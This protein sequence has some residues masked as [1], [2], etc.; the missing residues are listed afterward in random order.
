MKRQSILVLA[1]LILVVTGTSRAVVTCYIKTLD[2]T[3]YRDGCAVGSFGPS[4]TYGQTFTVP[5]GYPFLQSAQFYVNVWPTD[6]KFA[7]STLDFK[8]YVAAW[9][10]NA[11]T[12]S[13]LF[14]GPLISMGI[15]PDEYQY[16]SV[17]VNFNGL[18]LNI[19]EQYIIIASVEPMGWTGKAN[20]R[21]EATCHDSGSLNDGFY[22]TNNID[23][24]NPPSVNWMGAKA[25]PEDF[26]LLYRIELGIIPAPSAILI[27]S[28][29]VAF[30]AWLRR[31]KTI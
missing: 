16:Q 25:P 31:R 24:A 27:G 12:G 5:D 28:I 18:S 20:G 17:W 9:T 13:P 30:V 2:N 10:G 21:W 29:G 7:T 11:T 19:G 22:Y 4:G 8:F 15:S 26:D 3:N 14:V 23:F 1:A 6:P